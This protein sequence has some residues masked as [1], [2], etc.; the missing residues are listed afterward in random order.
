VYK[1]RF[2][3][4]K[5]RF[6]EYQLDQPPRY[7]A[8]GKFIVALVQANQDP[9][10]WYLNVYEA[11]SLQL[12][13]ETDI[14]EWNPQKDRVAQ[15]EDSLTVPPHFGA[16]IVISPDRR[17]AAIGTYENSFR[18][19]DLR[20]GRELAHSALARPPFFFTPDGTRLITDHA[21]G[22]RIW[23]LEKFCQLW[24]FPSPEQCSS[25][26]VQALIRLTICLG[27]RLLRPHVR[28]CAKNP[29]TPR[30]LASL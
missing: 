14:T 19:F 22:V 9:R 12:T 8:D 20:S 4:G 7:T 11:D 24:V 1:N 23:N 27:R 15:K 26:S 30:D 25:G 2:D 16:M 6:F 10:R 28:L 17:V 13:N 3:A 18:L 29:R 21:A 5:D